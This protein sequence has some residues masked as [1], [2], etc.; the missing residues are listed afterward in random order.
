MLRAATKQKV[1][2]LLDDSYFGSSNF[3]VEFEDGDP[4][5]TTITFIPNKNFYFRVSQASLGT[6]LY[7]AEAAPG[8][9]L[10][11]P[12]T[13]LTQSFEGC[14][15]KIPDWIQRVKEEVIDSNPLNRELQEVRRQLEEKIDILGERQDDF[16]TRTEASQLADKLNEFSEKLETLAV[17]N[18]ELNDVVRRLRTRIE[19]LV[20][21]TEE[22]NKGTWLRMAGSR[23]LGTAK[24]IIGSKEGREFALEAA[25]KVLLEGPK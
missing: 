11:K 13:L 19:E 20:A 5:W 15:A 8:V 7:R 22:I 24:A 3:A 25:K 21:A 2:G 18:S 1:I 14:V 17:E 6:V 9:Q 16:F 12:D 10:L 4:V 23:L